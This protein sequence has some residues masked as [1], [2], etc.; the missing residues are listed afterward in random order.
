V[1]L[2]LLNIFVSLYSFLI[3]LDTFKLNFIMLHK[4]NN[5]NRY[6]SKITNVLEVWKYSYFDMN[7]VA[8]KLAL[9]LVESYTIPM[10]RHNSKITSEQDNLITK[11]QVKSLFKNNWL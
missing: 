10:K 8:E 7:S 5:G 2:G 9:S 3:H 1:L 4:E 11:Y 6:A